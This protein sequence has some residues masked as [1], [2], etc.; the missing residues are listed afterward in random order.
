MALVPKPLYNGGKQYKTTNEAAFTTAMFTSSS[1]GDGCR[2]RFF[3]FINGEPVNI[4]ASQLL[5]YIRFAYKATKEATPLAT[6]RLNI[7]GDLQQRWNKAV[8]AFTSP[9][10]PFQFVF[11]GHLGSSA[12][13]M[14]VYD[15]SYDTNC[16][17]SRVPPF[18]DATTTTTIAPSSTVKQ[19]SV[20]S[21]T[22]SSKVNREKP[23]TGSGNAFVV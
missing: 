20:P 23:H 13:R 6:L 2:M 16:V 11:S 19:T 10:S 4:S 12:S 5:I 18:A 15:I 21:S 22:P 9:T 17:Y 7:N 14:A 3:Y 8:V 1:S